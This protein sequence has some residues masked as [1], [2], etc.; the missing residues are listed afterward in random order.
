LAPALKLDVLAT[1]NAPFCVIAPF[2]VT[3]NVPPTFDAPNKVA[4]L[5]IN[6]ALPVPLVVKETAPVKLFALLKV[7]APLAAVVLKLAV[8]GTVNTPV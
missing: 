1:I 3:D 8:P 4:M 7:I 2:D 6:D 5:F